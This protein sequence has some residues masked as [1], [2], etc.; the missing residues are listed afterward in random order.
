[1]NS[2]MKITY[3]AGDYV[4]VPDVTALVA[5]SLDSALHIVSRELVGRSDACVLE[6]SSLVLR[7]VGSEWHLCYSLVVSS[8]WLR[9]RYAALVDAVTGDVLSSWIHG[10]FFPPPDPNTAL[11]LPTRFELYQNFPNPFNPATEIVFDVPE[12]DRIKL[13]IYNSLGQR[14]RT[15]VDRT[16]E[17]G[18]HSYYF[19]GSGI[20]SGVY[21]YRLQAT[22]FEKTRRMIFVK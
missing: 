21:F 11:I 15:L 12:A 1:M 7:T 14:V 17:A 18:I 6:D 5:V 9:Y 16:L 8:D 10:N 4:A 3:I 22:N 20:A 19:D 13:V 2:E